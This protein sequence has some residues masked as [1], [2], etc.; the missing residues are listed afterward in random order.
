MHSERIDDIM[1]QGAVK[2]SAKPTA[3]VANKNLKPQ[4]GRVIKPK[5]AKLISQK[6]ML[7]VRYSYLLIHCFVSAVL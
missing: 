7:K 3:K 5:K 2:K 4:G 1:A 6:K